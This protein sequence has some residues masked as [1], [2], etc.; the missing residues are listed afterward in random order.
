MLEPINDVA[1]KISVNANNCLGSNSRDVAFQKKA[2][3]GNERP[4]VKSLNS[5]D[6]KSD[7]DYKAGSFNSDD[8]GIFYE[9]YDDHGNV[10]LRVPQERI[11]VDQFI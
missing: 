9:K 3:F 4:N 8:D 5:S 1:V 10:I 11:N 2:E 7:I 6:K